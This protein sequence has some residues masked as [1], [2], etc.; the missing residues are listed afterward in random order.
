MLSPTKDMHE[1]SEK[2]HSDEA[3]ME[4]FLVERGK[5]CERATQTWWGRF[6]LRN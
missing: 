1:Y 3:K 5:P 4:T 2:C 6:N